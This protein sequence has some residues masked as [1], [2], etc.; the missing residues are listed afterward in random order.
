V[1]DHKYITTSC[2]EISP[3]AALLS[4]NFMVLQLLL[5]QDFGGFTPQSMGSAGG[6]LSLLRILR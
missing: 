6:K 5:L 2:N 3:Y 4:P 1:D